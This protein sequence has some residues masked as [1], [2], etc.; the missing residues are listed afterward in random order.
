MIQHSKLTS[1]LSYVSSLESSSWPTFL[2]RRWRPS[3]PFWR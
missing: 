2:N 3:N 1:Q